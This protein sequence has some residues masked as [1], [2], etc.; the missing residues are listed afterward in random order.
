MLIPLVHGLHPNTARRATLDRL[1]RRLVVA[2]PFSYPC[3]RSH[4]DWSYRLKTSVGVPRLLTMH[5]RRLVIWFSIATRVG[6]AGA[7]AAQ[8][9]DAR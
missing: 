2:G 5:V 8:K 4:L 1:N 9:P 6:R 7:P 3:T